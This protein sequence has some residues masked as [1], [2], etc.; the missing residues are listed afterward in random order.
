M[1]FQ[2][3]S[4][5]VKEFHFIFQDVASFLGN[6]ITRRCKNLY[7]RSF[8]K[9]PPLGVRAPPYLG[10]GFINPFLKYSYPS[11]ACGGLFEKVTFFTSVFS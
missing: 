1:F 3:E 9:N 5:V 2:G 7:Q 10:G 11:G 6:K 4:S 8:N